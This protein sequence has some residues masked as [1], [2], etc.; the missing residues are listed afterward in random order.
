[1]YDKNPRQQNAILE[2]KI[3]REAICAL[4]KGNL[5]R[6]FLFPGMADLL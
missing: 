4:P 1:M 5:P 6:L 3:A 2:K